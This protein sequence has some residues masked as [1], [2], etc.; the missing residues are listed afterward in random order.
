M[1]E[2]WPCR[3]VLLAVRRRNDFLGWS[4][5][6]CLLRVIGTSR[7]FSFQVPRFIKCRRTTL[8]RRRFSLWISIF[9]ISKL[10]IM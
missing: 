3:D 5:L 8:S 9:N 10:W 4:D 2:A 6:E 1:A 7:V